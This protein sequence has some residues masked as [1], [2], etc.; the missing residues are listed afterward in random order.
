MSFHQQK[1]FK[2]LLVGDDGIDTYRY[3]E[4][5][6]ISPEA[7]V[8]VFEPRW[9]ITLAGMAANVH[10][11]LEA[12]GCEVKFQHSQTCHKQRLID[13]KSKQHV[14]RIDQDA[15]CDE[16]RIGFVSSAELCTYDAVVVS[17]YNKGTV[18]YQLIQWL[19]AEYTGPIFV[20]T[21]KTELD[22][23]P[24]C[25]IKINQIERDR[26]KTLPEPQWLVVTDGAAGAR[27]QDRLI[28]AAA[29]GNVVDVCGAGD[30]FLSAMVFE[31]LQTQ[32][33]V[34]AIEFA[35]RAS[36]VTVQHVGVYAPTLKEIQ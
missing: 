19:R 9:E 15:Q 33:I 34:R 32:N 36:A 28:P 1:K 29:A 21:K 20:D 8:P 10:R 6:R 30:T 31:Y 5:T 24:G 4:I 13:K 14:L 23:L 26:A 11:N 17:D 3:G 2:I 18:S 22:Q 12:L 35:N 7:P 25:W 16:L 27:Y